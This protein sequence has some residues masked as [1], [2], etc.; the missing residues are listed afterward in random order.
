[1]KYFSTT[2]R[3]FLSFVLIFMFVASPLVYAQ[4]S[5]IDQKLNETKAGIDKLL[6]VK[7]S[8]T[9]SQS[10]KTKQEIELKTTLLLNILDLSLAQLNDLSDKVDHVSFSDTDDWTSIKTS[11]QQRLADAIAYYKD[12]QKWVLETKKPMTTQEIALGGKKIADQQSTTVD[13]L[14][15]E[16]NI[17]LSAFNIDDIISLADGRLE[18]V[19]SDVDKIYSN[20][21]T[22]NQKLKTLFDSALALVEKS[23]EQSDRAKEVILHLYDPSQSTSTQA[24]I[25]GLGKTL[26]TSTSTLSTLV[27]RPLIESYV[28]DLIF[29]ALD[30]VKSAYAIFLDMSANAKQYLK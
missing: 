13:S 19:G 4:S 28:Q 22:K 1:M 26:N 14:V 10:E 17:I 20:N 18:K 8:I 29:G 15:R 3:I 21:L 25:D 11:Y 30:A 12:L 7:D 23:H 6:E 9:L 16:V 24:F 5:A 2:A 27:A